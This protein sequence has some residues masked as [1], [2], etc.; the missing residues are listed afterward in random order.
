MTIEGTQNKTTRRRPPRFELIAGAVCLDF[1]NTLDD[2]F[3]N[4]PKEL[5]ESYLDLARFGED[6]GIIDD[7]VVDRLIARTE[8]SP[9]EAKNALEAGIELREAMF[10][11]FTAIAT[12]KQI[13]RVPLMTLN[14]YIQGAAQHAQLVPADTGQVTKTV[15]PFEW[16]FDA[17]PLGCK[18]PLW[19][20]AR[21]AAD[22]L[23][24]DQLANVRMCAAKNCEWFFLDTSK[25][26]ARRWCDM[27]KCGNRAKARAFYTRQKSD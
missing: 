3:T 16:R 26:H 18:D 5:L 15:A 13:P 2:R 11:V 1:I 12:K 8:T 17:L 25:N 22:L 14:G 19:P 4:Q 6:S 7:S 21:S 23:A 10:A 9:A 27:T 24:S 20:I